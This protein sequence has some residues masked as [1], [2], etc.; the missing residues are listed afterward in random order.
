MKDDEKKLSDEVMNKVVGGTDSE[1]EYEFITC[2]ECGRR[3]CVSVESE[4][5]AFNLCPTCYGDR[6]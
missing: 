3:I 5:Y 4:Y 6:E 1:E 2:S